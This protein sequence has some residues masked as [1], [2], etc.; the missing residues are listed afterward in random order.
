MK[1]IRTIIFL[2]ICTICFQHGYS[3]LKG[4]LTVG[5]RVGVN[6]ANVNLEEAQSVRGSIIGL[7]SNVLL[8]KFSVLTLEALYSKEG[9]ELPTSLIDYRYLQIPLLY[10]TFFG[11]PGDPFRPKIYAGFSPGLLLRAEVNGVDFKDQHESVVLNLVG[12]LGFQYLLTQR[13]W[14]HLD[15]RAVLG[16]TPIELSSIRAVDFRNKNF[17]LSLGVLYGI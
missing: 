9:Y 7:S 15:A 1:I 14:I 10:N 5:P 3:Q 12:G 2:C 17:Q 16:L 6:F 13:L 4:R 8:G 11:L